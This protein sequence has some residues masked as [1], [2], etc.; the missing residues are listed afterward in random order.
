MAVQLR[1]GKEL[2]MKT[3]KVGS[4]TEKESPEREG[5]LERKKEKVDR[6]DI[7]DS[8]PAVPFP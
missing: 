1:S 7:H 2:E 6:K 3:E 4:S 8:V 5:E